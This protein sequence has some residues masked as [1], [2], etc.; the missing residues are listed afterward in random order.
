MIKNFAV[1]AIAIGIICCIASFVSLKQIKR[2]GIIQ[3]VIASVIFLMALE[4]FYVAGYFILT[5]EANTIDINGVELM[6]W[7]V[8][9]LLAQIPVFY[10]FLIF[11]LDKLFGS[12]TIN[13]G[14]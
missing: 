7:V 11:I 4:W 12:T 14:T 9:P 10:L 13:R 1:P 6:R 8:I 3:A 5:P 2:Y